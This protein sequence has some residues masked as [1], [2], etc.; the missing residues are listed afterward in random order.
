MAY[1][2]SGVEVVSASSDKTVKVRFCAPQR[3]APRHQVMQGEGSKVA[4]WAPNFQRQKNLWPKLEEGRYRVPSK[5]KLLL[6]VRNALAY[7]AAAD[8]LFCQALLW[9]SVANLRVLVGFL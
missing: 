3:L 2:P 1:S 7:K 6:L 5:G 4:K 8:P 9:C